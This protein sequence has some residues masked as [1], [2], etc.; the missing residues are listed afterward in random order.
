MFSRVETITPEIAQQY[1]ERNLENN[2]RLST[3]NI[4]LYANAMQSGDWQL[5]SQGISFNESGQL[6]DGQHRLMAIIK[7]GVPVKMY[8]TYGEP[9]ESIIHDRGRGRSINDV[10]NMSGDIKITPAHVSLTNCIFNFTAGTCAS[11]P[12]STKMR[13]IAGNESL[14]DEIIDA[15]RKGANHAIAKTAPAQSAAFF[16]VLSG[17]SKETIKKFFCVLNSGFQE[18]SSQ[19]AAIVARKFIESG[20]RKEFDYYNYSARRRVFDV[21]SAA[22]ADFSNGISRRKVYSP[23]AENV[24]QESINNIKSRYL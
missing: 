10:M 7:A 19:S 3:K 6:T 23:G 22:L 21:V 9:D 8:V 11:V 14:L 16:G 15:S 2:R 12:D 20:W 13:F 5:T 24:F 4:A 17:I 1:L 18:S